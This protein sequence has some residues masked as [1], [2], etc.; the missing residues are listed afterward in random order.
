MSHTIVGYCPRCGAP[1]YSP[2]VWMGTTPPPASYSCACFASATPAYAT[3]TNPLQTSIPIDDA[4][5]SRA[6]HALVN[7]QEARIRQLEAALEKERSKYIEVDVFEDI[8][9]VL[10]TYIDSEIK[11]L[12]GSP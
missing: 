2:M 11:K 8:V 3:S 10:V 12:R 1:I 6:L 4:G 7:V 9:R 5:D